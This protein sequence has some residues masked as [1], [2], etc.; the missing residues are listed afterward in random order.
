MQYDAV[1]I[2]DYDKGYLSKNDLEV[3]CQ[4]FNGPVFIDTKKTDLFTYPNVFFKINQREY[5]RLIVKPDAKNLIVTLGEGGSVYDGQVFPAEKVNVFDVVGAGDTFL[6]ALVVKFLETN[7]IVR[8]IKFAQNCSKK[9][10][11]QLGISVVGDLK[12]KKPKII[13]N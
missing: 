1:V 2:S 10:V 6:S 4:N 12:N 9:V 3:F 8:S 11:S 7:N 13:K 5:D